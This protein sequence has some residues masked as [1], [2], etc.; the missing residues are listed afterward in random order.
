MNMYTGFQ[1]LWSVLYDDDKA[2][3]DVISMMPLCGLLGYIYLHDDYIMIFTMMRCLEDMDIRWWLR[4]TTSPYGRP[5]LEVAYGELLYFTPLRLYWENSSGRVVGVS[6]CCITHARHTRINTS[7]G[8]ITLFSCF[9]DI[10]TYMY[11][12][13]KIYIYCIKEHWWSLT[14]SWPDE[15]QRMFSIAYEFS[16]ENLNHRLFYEHFL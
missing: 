13:F 15:V 7:V 8:S 11:Y 14:S 4:S 2:W 1:S 10:K 12:A 6:A 3:Y 16:K 5:V 9:Y